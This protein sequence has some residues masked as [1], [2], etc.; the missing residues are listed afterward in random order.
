[1]TTS[2]VT[3]DTITLVPPFIR[4]LLWAFAI[5]AVF[6]VVVIAAWWLA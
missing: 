1:M 6:A 5:E 2:L 4:G 3:N